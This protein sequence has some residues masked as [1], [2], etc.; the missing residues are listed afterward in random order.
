MIAIA[1]AA[2]PNP[3]HK[4]SDKTGPL[5]SRRSLLISGMVMPAIVPRH[6]LGGPAHQAPSEKLRIA[7]AGVG[8]MGR[9]YIGNCP[10]D[11]I[12]ALCGVDH[13]YAKK[14]F[15]RYVKGARYRDFR[16]IFGK[17]AKNFDALIIGTP[18]HTHAIILMSALKLG[19]HIYC[20]KPITHTIGEAREVRGARRSRRRRPVW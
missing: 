3:P 8:G 13:N 18:D 14:V 9:A 4:T 7:A 6:V 20:A 2:I 1:S 15:G 10:H 12:V 19:K 17:E 5:L 16:K 11:H